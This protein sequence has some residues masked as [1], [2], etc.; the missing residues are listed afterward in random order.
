MAMTNKYGVVHE[1][2]YMTATFLQN[3]FNSRQV[4]SY[5]L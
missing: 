3:N 5:L 2:S 1:I 4:P